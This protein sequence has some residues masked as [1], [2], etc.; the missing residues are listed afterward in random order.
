LIVVLYGCE[1]WSLA[2]RDKYG[3]KMFESR[4]LRKAFKLKRDKVMGERR[5][6]QNKEPSALYSS[7]NIIQVI[8][9]RK[10]RWA[11]HVARR[12]E[13]MCIHGSDGDD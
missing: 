10:M 8:K 3:L 12:G 2:L 7:P 1:A 11:R 6:L 9:S 5:R 13:E 4:V